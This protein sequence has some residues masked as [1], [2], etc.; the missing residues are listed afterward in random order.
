VRAIVAAAVMGAAL[1]ASSAAS[2]RTTL[3]IATVN[4]SDMIRMQALAGDFI[5]RNPDISLKWVTLEEN[6]LRQRVTLDIATGGGQF[7]IVT[8]GSYEV[9]IW[10]KRGWLASLDDL[11]PQLDTQD[12]LPSIR[13]ALT[14]SGQLRASPFYAE[15][16]ITLYRKDL[17]GKAGL[18]M[19]RNP[20]WDFIALAAQKLTDR[21]EGVYGICLRGKAGWGENMA[22]ITVMGNSFGARWFDMAWRPQFDRPEWRRT[23]ATYVDLLRRYG[24]PGASSNGFNENLALF[25][26]GRCAMWID[27]SVAASFV[28][29]PQASRVAGKVGFALAP[30]AGLGKTA[31]WLWIWSLAIPAETRNAAAAKRF[32]GWATGRHYLDLVAAKYGWALVPPGT[33]QSLYRD[34]RY[35]KAAPFAALTLEAIN[36]ANPD[37]PTVAPVPYV[38]VQ[39]VAL[40]VFQGLG[41]TVGQEFSAAVSG[42]ATVD[43]ALAAAQSSAL[44]EI[45]HAGYIN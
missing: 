9:P 26:S 8:I 31:G 37:R 18:V 20:S 4:N 10:G 13:A 38:G 42:A 28:S 11:S 25:N 43:D 33:R 40:P 29:D 3:T 23:L 21:A 44:R 15:S 45:R 7:D 35:L 39:Y 5:A 24:P 36:A 12:F 22:L 1:L 17:F 16:S 32:I 27:A 30:N 41:T 2:A 34:P 19:P 6:V 14:V